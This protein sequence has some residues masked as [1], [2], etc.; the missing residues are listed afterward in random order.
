[1]INPNTARFIIRHEYTSKWFS[2]CPPQNSRCENVWRYLHV[3]ISAFITK[4]HCQ[5]VWLRVRVVLSAAESTHCLRWQTLSAN[6]HKHKTPSIV[7]SE[8]LSCDDYNLVWHVALL[9]VMRSQ[10][11]C[12]PLPRRG[13][14]TVDITWQRRLHQLQWKDADLHTRTDGSIHLMAL[15]L[16]NVFNLKDGHYLATLDCYKDW[17]LNAQNITDREPLLPLYHR[18]AKMKA[19]RVMLLYSSLFTGSGWATRRHDNGGVPGCHE[20]GGYGALITVKTAVF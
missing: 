16:Q 13:P 10:W 11:G 12:L 14:V 19:N 3:S 2:F 15:K 9:C 6:E 20:L 8:E 1:M 7:K 18:R 17:S 4:T 5:A